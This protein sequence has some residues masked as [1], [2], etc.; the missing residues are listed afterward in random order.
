VRAQ[1]GREQECPFFAQTGQPTL[2]LAK[3]AD[4]PT[5]EGL[6]RLCALASAAGGEREPA[7]AAELGEQYAARAVELLRQA[8]GKGYRDSVYLKKGTDLAPLR[9]RAD[10]QKLLAEAEAKRETPGP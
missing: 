3:D 6:A 9:Q 2:T 7:K 8:V 4:G 5:L 10:F 1:I